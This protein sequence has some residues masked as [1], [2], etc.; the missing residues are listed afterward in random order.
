M[1]TRMWP[2]Q[3][4]IACAVV[5]ISTTAQAG[6]VVPDVR[7]FSGLEIATPAQVKGACGDVVEPSDVQARIAV[8][9]PRFDG[10]FF[11]NATGDMA[12]LRN[13]FFAMMPAFNDRA[14]APNDA[15]AKAAWSSQV[16]ANQYKLV[17]LASHQVVMMRCYFGSA[18]TSSGFDETAM[19]QA[20]AALALGPA[21]P[22]PSPEKSRMNSIHGWFQWSAFM[23]AIAEI[24]PAYKAPED[25]AAWENMRR[26]VLHG[27][28][29][30]VYHDSLCPGT[31]CQAKPN[32][33]VPGLNATDRKA[34]RAYAYDPAINPKDV[35]DR[36][37]TALLA[38]Q[39]KYPMHVLPKSM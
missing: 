15:A 35:L 22:D 34:I 7:K 31:H 12:V 37:Y 23:D 28:L 18:G 26:H 39:H 3:L 19:E 24:N 27:L 14:R 13:T 17:A 6:V 38:E 20:F 30:H 4:W 1:K 9:W 29:L 11:T 21:V 33:A 16:T 5:V 36:L 8:F 25:V 10:V 2:A 32:F